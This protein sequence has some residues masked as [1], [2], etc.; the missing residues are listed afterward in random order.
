MGIA[1]S[2]AANATWTWDSDGT[3]R[4]AHLADSAGLHMMNTPVQSSAVVNASP[5]SPEHLRAIEEGRTRSKKVRRAAA[6]AKGSGWTLA[7]FAVITLIG[8]AFGDVTSL[9]MGAALGG[10]AFNELRGGRMIARFDAKGASVLGGNQL[11]LGAAIVAY[12]GWSLY[13]ATKDPALARLAGG[14]TGDADVDATVQSIANFATYGLYGTLAVGGVVG[15][16]L[17]ALYYY[18]RA[19]IVRQLI[20][21]TPTWVLDT[22]R[23]AA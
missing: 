21:E 19:R 1:A 8:A 13:S 12:S 23:A 4:V 10:L 16:G 3:K 22:M 7:I 17:T 6:V 11:M 18:T 5:L 20:E 14:S 15:C 2:Y 9:V